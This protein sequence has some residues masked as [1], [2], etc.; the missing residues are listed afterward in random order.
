MPGAGE[1][2]V[3]RV[4]LHGDHSIAFGDGFEDD[5]VSVGGFVRGYTPPDG[6]IAVA[7]AELGLGYRVSDYGEAPTISVGAGIEY[8][9][10][11]FGLEHR[12]IDGLGVIDSHETA[13]VI[14]WRF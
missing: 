1:I 4:E 7:Y 13:I 14:G 5:F 6:G 2:E 10:L 8:G 3:G 11:T 12:R 9:P